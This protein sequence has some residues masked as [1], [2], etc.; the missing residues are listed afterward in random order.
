VRVVELGEILHE[1]QLGI[2]WKISKLVVIAKQ[3][4]SEEIFLSQMFFK[5]LETI[6]LVILREKRLLQ[7]QEEY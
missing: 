3:K 6:I 1:N 7:E 5:V 4:I 2:Y